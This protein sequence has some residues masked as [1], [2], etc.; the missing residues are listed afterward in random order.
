M[1][2]FQE[3]ISLRKVSRNHHGVETLK[4]LIEVAGKSIGISL[5]EASYSA[6]RITMNLW[7]AQIDLLKQQMYSL[8]KQLVELTKKHLISRFSLLSKV[9]RI[10]P[11]PDPLLKTENSLTILIIKKLRPLPAPIL[12]FVNLEPIWD[13]EESPTLAITDS[14]L[15]CTK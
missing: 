12:E 2:V 14:E 6:E 7:I 15:Y 4:A 11:Q 1:N 10:S 9:S 8:L 3:L 5:D 13:I